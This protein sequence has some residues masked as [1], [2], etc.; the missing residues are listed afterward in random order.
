MDPNMPST[1]RRASSRRSP[2][3]SQTSLSLGDNPRILARLHDLRPQGLRIAL[4]DFGTGYSRR[5]SS[6]G[7]DRSRGR[8]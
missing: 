1:S 2:G 8:L 3:R 7:M 6:V 4:D 5:P